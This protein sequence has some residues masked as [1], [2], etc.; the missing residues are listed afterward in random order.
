MVLAVA[1]VGLG[2]PM[3]F[4]KAASAAT[5]GRRGGQ[6]RQAQTIARGP[7]AA[8]VAIKQ[9]GTNGGGYFGPNST[10]PF[11]N[12]SPWTNLLSIASIV[13]LPM[14]SIVMA[15][16]DAASNT[17]HAMVIYGVMLTFL[18]TGAVIAILAEVRPS[19]ATRRAA[20]R[21][22]ARTWR[23][24]RSASARSPARRGRR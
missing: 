1:L 5:S 13:M 11:E 7:V 2:V 15:G 21:A 9:A 12:P 16:A 14:S 18:V 22:I 6:D 19:L 23:G 8:L 3:T 20:G 24:R 10:H 17:K 4:E